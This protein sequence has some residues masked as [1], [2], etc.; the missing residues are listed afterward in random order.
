M[1]SANFIGTPS[2]INANERANMHKLCEA[3]SHPSKRRKQQLNTSGFYMGFAGRWPEY[4]IRAVH[5]NLHGS[6]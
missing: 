1:R 5:N 6:T 3:T 4:D 2:D